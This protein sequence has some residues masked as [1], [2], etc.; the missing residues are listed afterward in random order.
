SFRAIL[1]DGDCLGLS[2]SRD[3]QIPNL[4]STHKIVLV[5]QTPCHEALLLHHIAGHENKK[6]R[7]AASAMT[8]LR[9]CWPEYSKGS[10][11]RYLATKLGMD[12]IR[13]ACGVDAVLDGFL[14]AIQYFGPGYVK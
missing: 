2:P 13:R 1:L 5:W 11:A 4:C 3:R 10:T 7:T 14:R 9:R 8:E 6:P 12:D